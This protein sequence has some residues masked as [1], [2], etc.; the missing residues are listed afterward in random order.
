MKI[1]FYEKGKEEDGRMEMEPHR[2]EA[3]MYFSLCPV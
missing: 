3:V 1:A 2:A